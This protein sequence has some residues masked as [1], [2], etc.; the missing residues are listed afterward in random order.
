MQ[1]VPI[2]C[3]LSIPVQR[4]PP[5]QRT[6]YNWTRCDIPAYTQDI[7]DG[8]LNLN[9]IPITC[10]RGI[11]NRL[12]E[13]QSIIQIGMNKCIPVSKSCPYKRPYWDDELDSVIVTRKLNRLNGYNM[14]DHEVWSIIHIAFINKPNTNLPNYLNVNINS[15]NNLDLKKQNQTLKQIP[16]I[17]GNLSRTEIETLLDIMP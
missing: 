5:H 4:H 2:I 11:D 8:L 17:C 9:N 14:A 3:E 10:I 13:L 1:H 15:I 6:M 16:G 12:Q 7:R